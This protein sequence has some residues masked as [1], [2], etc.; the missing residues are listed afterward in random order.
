MWGQLTMSL[1][2]ALRAGGVVVL[3]GG[4]FLLG[5]RYGNETPFRN[6]Q[7]ATAVSPVPV[8][9]PLPLTPSEQAKPLEEIGPSRAAEIMRYGFPGFDNLRTFEDYVLSYDRKTRTAHWVCEHLTPTSLIYDPSVDRSKCEF[10]ADPSIHKYFQSENTDYRGSGYDRGHLA[11]AGNHRK[12][13][14][15]VDQTFLLTNMSPQVGRGFNRDKWNDLEKYARKVA[16]KS[17][18]TY[19]LTGP[20]Y[21]PRKADDGNK[22]VRYKVI[23]ANNVAVPTHFFKV[24]LAETSPS[25]FEMECF[26][27]PNEVSI[28]KVSSILRV[29]N[30]QYRHGMSVDRLFDIKNAFFLGHYQ[31]CILEAQKLIT[32]VEEEK[33]AKDVFT[34]RSYIAQGKASVVLSEISERTDNPSLKAVRRLAEYQTPSNKKRIANEVQTEVSSGTAPTDDTSCIV[35]ALILN[36]ESNPEDAMRILSKSSSL[37]ARS[38]TVFTLLQMDRVDLA[39]KELKKMNEIDEDATLTQLALAWVNMAVGKDKLKDAYY[40]YQEMMDKYGQS[41]Q[42]LVSQS[43]VLILQGKY[44][45]AEALLHEAQLRDANNCDALVNLVAVSQFL[46]KDHEVLKRYIAQLRDIDSTHPWVADL[47]A[48]EAL[49]DELVTA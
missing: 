8:V 9:P 31:Q 19:I 39:V 5:A 2:A 13:Q 40:I 10:R 1:R 15:S 38:A 12:T 47:Q 6:L 30:P 7:A 46:G 37:E 45:E 25:N 29:R 27:L 48:K 44:K 26:V 4:S 42:L 22:Y 28:L 36:E 49:F 23:G 18:N 32:K 35:A 41:P 3:A 17:L 34:Y 16:K 43:A 33:L 14:N 21:L 20:L 24:I 11:A